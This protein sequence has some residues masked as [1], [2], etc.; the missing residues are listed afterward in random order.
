MCYNIRG[1]RKERGD[2]TM[3]GVKG[4]KALRINMAFTDDVYRYITLMS[5]IK[6]VSMTKFVNNII[7]KDMQ[8]NEAYLKN[9]E[10][11]VNMVK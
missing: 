2:F 10:A 9:I 6:G 7:E 3:Q 8:K 5:K 4:T 1:T 11:V